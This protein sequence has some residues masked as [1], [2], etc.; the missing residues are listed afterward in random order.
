MEKIRC[1]DR[2]E[3]EEEV[4]RVKEKMNMLYAIKR[5]K[6]K[7]VSHILRGNCRLKTFMDGKTRDKEK[8]DTGWS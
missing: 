8:L 5:W 7:W 3:N 2:V 4:H 1:T 6:A